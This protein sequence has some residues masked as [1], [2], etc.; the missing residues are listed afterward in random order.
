[1]NKFDG[2]DFVILALARWDGPYSSTAFSIAQELSKTNR[3]FYIDHPFTMKD[4]GKGWRSQQIRKR[5]MSLLL[6]TKPCQQLPGNDNF[7]CVTP[8]MALPIN[9][10]W[11][12]K[13]YNFFSSIN[14]YRI[15]RTLEKV[16]KKK[17]LANFIFLN[18]FNPFYLSNI[19][20]FNPCCKV[21]Y[22]VD[23]MS[24]SKYINK[25]G[26]EREQILMRKYDLTISTSKFLQKYA[27]LY[28]SRS[29]YLPN[30]A[31]FSLFKS[32]F[33]IDPDQ[34]PGELKN[35][36]KKIVGYI[37]NVEDRIDFGLLIEVVKMNPDK[38][39]LFI[40]PINSDQFRKLGFNQQDNVITVGRKD[41]QELPT[42]LR[43]IDCAI[44]PF[45]K[46]KLTEG[47]YP[48]KINEYLASGRPVVTTSFSEDIL[49][50]KDIV[51]VADSALEFSEAIQSEMDADDD[52]KRKNRAARASSNTWEDRAIRLQNLLSIYL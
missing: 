5:L 26:V 37:G 44:I 15:S 42:Y 32:T 1:M 12:G 46:N 35:T 34:R 49:E 36:T 41:I 6:G 10:L 23:N 52:E 4:V 13:I 9:F 22:C 21:Y 39:F 30:A 8:P 14:N 24:E 48:L 20:D 7:F 43:F 11:K 45:K 33:L 27:A 28:T 25:H 31:D 50:F 18:V 29:H 38:V 47:I 17:Q 51:Q 40:G 3:V 16:C 2:K 19:Q